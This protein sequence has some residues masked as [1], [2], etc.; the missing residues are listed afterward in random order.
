M[1]SSVEEYLYQLYQF[2]KNLNDRTL[3]AAS[4]S[5]PSTWW[6]WWEIAW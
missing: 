1:L 5:N 2:K 3:S 4:P 6:A